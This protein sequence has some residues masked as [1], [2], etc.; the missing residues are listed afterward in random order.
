MEEKNAMKPEQLNGELLEG[1]TG[2]AVEVPFDPAVQWAISAMPL[3]RGRHGHH[4]H[5]ILNGVRFKSVVVPRARKFFVL[6][7]ESL[8]EAARVAV[9]DTVEITLMPIVE[10]AAKR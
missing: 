3:W 7:D 8:Q 6:V 10:G 4:V 9:G 1:H 5:G 2:A